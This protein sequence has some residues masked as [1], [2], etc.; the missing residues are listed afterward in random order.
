MKKNS[1][2]ILLIFVCLLLSACHH[3]NVEGN[4]ADY[5]PKDGQCVVSIP[6]EYNLAYEDAEKTLMLDAELANAQT[7]NGQPKNSNWQYFCVQKN[8]PFRIVTPPTVIQNKNSNF[9]TLKF[10][11]INGTTYEDC[12]GYL[13]KNVYTCAQNAVI[14]PVYCPFRA[15]GMILFL[16]ENG[17]TPWEFFDENGNVAEGIFDKNG[18]I[19]S[20]ENVKYLFGTYDFNPSRDA[21]K[22]NLDL[23]S[24]NVSFS[25]EGGN[26]VNAAQ[27]T[28]TIS[29]TVDLTEYLKKG[30]VVVKSLCQI[31]GYGYMLNPTAATQT[32]DVGNTAMTGTFYLPLG[33]NTLQ[34]TFTN[35]M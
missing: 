19:I 9:Q 24:F 31:D 23:K 18:N 17:Q 27:K 30:A 4:S 32:I 12:D 20:Q 29:V 2:I 22:T 8:E 11:K 7:I 25:M 34:C 26:S 10:W 35:N 14:E 16:T 15:V 6:K 33:A 1:V 21:W 13:S 3:E 5:K 28:Y